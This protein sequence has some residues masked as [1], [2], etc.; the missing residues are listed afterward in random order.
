MERKAVCVQED[1]KCRDFNSFCFLCHSLP[2]EFCRQFCTF[3][4]RNL[5][6]VRWRWNVEWLHFI[7]RVFDSYE[8]GDSYRKMRKSFKFMQVPQLI[9]SLIFEHQSSNKTQKWTIFVWPKQI[10]NELWSHAENIKIISVA[11]PSFIFTSIMYFKTRIINSV[12]SFSIEKWIF[13]WMKLF[14]TLNDK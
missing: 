6:L 3:R 11:F 12:K 9:I 14:A 10:N 7:S 4:N 2:L 13:V 5:F 8:R 1:E